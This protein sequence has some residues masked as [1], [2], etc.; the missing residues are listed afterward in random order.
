MIYSSEDNTEF[1]VSN[2]QCYCLYKQPALYVYVWSSPGTLYQYLRYSKNLNV[3][4]LIEY[5]VRLNTEEFWT[6]SVREF[7][8]ALYTDINN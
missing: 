1:P 3:R 7:T 4:E 2:N 6:F 5:V 8:M